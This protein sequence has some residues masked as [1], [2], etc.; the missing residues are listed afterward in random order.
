MAKREANEYLNFQTAAYLRF[1]VW[2]CD[3]CSLAL[4]RVFD[5]AHTVGMKHGDLGLQRQVFMDIQSALGCA[6]NVGKMLWP[7]PTDP[8]AA[9]IAIPR[10]ARLRALLKIETDPVLEDRRLRNSFEHLDERVDKW[11]QQPRKLMLNVFGPINVVVGWTHDEIFT[12]YD[13]VSRSV[14]MLRHTVSLFDVKTS[15]ERVQEA[16][17]AARTDI[18]SRLE[19]PEPLESPI[20]PSPTNLR[21]GDTL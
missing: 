14:R 5:Q 17:E 10:G 13:P 20:F 6:A 16:A 15:V 4:N 1:L 21:P 3:G 8:D 11:A 9:K 12:M 2:E 19:P 7:A 18:E